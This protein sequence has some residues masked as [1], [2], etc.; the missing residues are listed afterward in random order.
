VAGL[1]VHLSA[2]PTP[3]TDYLV[4]M[5]ADL[6]V[7]AWDLAR[8]VGG[9]TALDGELVAAAFRHAEENLGEHGVPGFIAAPV[10]VPADA[11]LQTRLLARFG[12]RP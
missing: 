9:V 8:A 1:T 7:H 2:G 5:T 4:E 10:E 6:T 12:R 3:A 11:D